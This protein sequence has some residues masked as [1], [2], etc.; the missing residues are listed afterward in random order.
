MGSKCDSSYTKSYSDD[1]IKAVS[2]Y[3]LSGI[4]KIQSDIMQHGSVTAAF[5]VYSDFP[6]YTSGVYKHTT[7]SALGG[8]AI[9]ILGWGVE[10]GTP[11]WLVANSWNEDWGMQ[12]FFKIERGTDQCQIENPI[13]NGGPVAGMPKASGIQIVV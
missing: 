11:Y 9:K 5:T 12:G 1:K 8:H 4:S 13:I 7:G 6:T 2:S 10:S 3:S